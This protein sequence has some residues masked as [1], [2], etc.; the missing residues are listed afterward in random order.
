MALGFLML[1]L[2]GRPRLVSCDLGFKGQ[3]R[4]NCQKTN[5]HKQ[6]LKSTNKQT[7]NLAHLSV[8]LMKCRT[9]GGVSHWWHALKGVSGRT[10]YSSQTSQRSFFV[11]QMVVTA[12]T[13]S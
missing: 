9:V 3:Q 8:L 7:K 11:Q 12:E 1:L 2:H 10:E 13:H 6:I 4:F 5:K